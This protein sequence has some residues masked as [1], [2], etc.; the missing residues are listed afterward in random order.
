MILLDYSQIALSNIIV[1]KMQDEDMIRH[2]I[3][4][5]IRMYNK[6]Y[7]KEYGQMVIC[8]DGMNTWRKEY[9]PQY[10]AHRK[11]SRGDSPLD[12]TEIFRVL[13]LVR[14]EIRD[15]LPYKVIHMEG[16][17]A[18]DIIGALTFNT[19][20][21]GNH[22][23][24]MIISSDKDFIQLHKFAH[25]KQFSPM[26]K[27]NVTEKHPRKYLFEHVCRGDSS[28]GIPNVLSADTCF[29][30]GIK[31]SPL[32]QK[33]IDTWIDDSSIMPE[34]IKRNFQRN[35]TLIDLS[36]IPEDIYNNIVNNFNEQKV[37]MK[38]KVLNYL[39]KKRCNN[40]IG[41]VEEFYNG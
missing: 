32:R 22:E 24:V 14:D 37:P 13:N 41:S 29:V 40:L 9:F 39:I 31:Q 6:R 1:Q 19:E 5:S 18:D 21:F 35:T 34:E 36:K 8:A 23:P 33:L 10:K 25:V 4:N 12:W 38:M 7:R 26:T 17:E 3:L 15:N 20:E 30:D 27:K 16:C 2:M 28:D 11:K